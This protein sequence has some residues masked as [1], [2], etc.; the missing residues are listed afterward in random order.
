MLLTQNDELILA[1]GRF[2]LQPWRLLMPHPVLLGQCHA[3]HMSMNMS[4]ENPNSQ[5]DRIPIL[6]ALALPSVTLFIAELLLS[7]SFLQDFYLQVNLGVHCHRGTH[8]FHV[9]VRGPV[10]ALQ[11]LAQGCRRGSLLRKQPSLPSCHHLQSELV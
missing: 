10:S 9:P 6:F 1:T 4:L 11:I 5:S 3:C 2:N 8:P 7:S